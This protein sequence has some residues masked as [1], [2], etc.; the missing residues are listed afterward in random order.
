MLSYVLHNFEPNHHEGR[1]RSVLISD[2]TV[3]AIFRRSLVTISPVRADSE[4]RFVLVLDLFMQFQRSRD[5]CSQI[6][7]LMHNR[8]APRSCLLFTRL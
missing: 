3:L 2:I 7:S 4:E 5:K 1:F 8:L 6:Y